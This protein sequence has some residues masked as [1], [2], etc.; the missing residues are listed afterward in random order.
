MRKNQ[1]EIK[2]PVLH[3]PSMLALLIREV[4]AHKEVVKN[5]EL[6]GLKD[7]KGLISSSN[8]C[9]VRT[10]NLHLDL[11]GNINM[12]SEKIDNQWTFK[13]KEKTEKRMNH[14][15]EIKRVLEDFTD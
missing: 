7:F 10:W 13:T 11:I 12:N 15:E 5:L 14:I 9:R 8:D 4:K 3:E 2:L 6:I 1:S